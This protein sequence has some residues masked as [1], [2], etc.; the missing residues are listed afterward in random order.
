MTSQ[1]NDR[2]PMQSL[3][4]QTLPM[5][6]R[7]RYAALAG[8]AIT[9]LSIAIFGAFA[10]IN[11]FNLVIPLLVSVGFSIALHYLL[12]SFGLREDHTTR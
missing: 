6:A 11:A 7:P 2:R 1:N 9:T 8:G 3:P 10:G 5:M 4:V 12:A